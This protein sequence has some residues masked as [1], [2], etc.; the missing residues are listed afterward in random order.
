MPKQF[1]Q[2]DVADSEGSI[3][4][5]SIYYTETLAEAEFLAMLELQQDWGD[6]YMP[7]AFIDA[8]GPE[9]DEADPQ[10]FPGAEAWNQAGYWADIPATTGMLVV[11]PVEALAQLGKIEGDLSAD[12][13]TAVMEGRRRLTVAVIV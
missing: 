3:W 6:S 11:P 1:Y 2:C 13:I 4:T 5:G 9:R 10:P 7:D 8:F 12:D